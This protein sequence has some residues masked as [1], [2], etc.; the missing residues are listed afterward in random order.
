MKDTV[1]RLCT[2]NPGEQPSAA[3]S[4]IHYAIWALKSSSLP[5]QTLPHTLTRQKTMMKG[6]LSINPSW[7]QRASHGLGS[8][9]ARAEKYSRSSQ[10]TDFSH[11]AHQ[12][13]QNLRHRSGVLGILG[14]LGILGGTVHEFW[15]S[16]RNCSSWISARKAIS[17]LP[18][19]NANLQRARCFWI[20]AASK[21]FDPKSAGFVLPGIFETLT[22]PSC[23]I[24]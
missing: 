5:H 20:E 16:V 19:R 6:W 2:L 8:T 9:V 18:A 11:Q 1:P 13:L 3:S 22:F 15:S 7:T 24:F 4:R 17:D 10:A 12:S 23:T 21:C 14:I